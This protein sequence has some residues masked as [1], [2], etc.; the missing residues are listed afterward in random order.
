MSPRVHLINPSELSFGVAVITPPGSRR[1]APPRVPIHRA[2]GRQFL[3][4]HDVRSRGCASARRPFAPG[5]ARGNPRRSGSGLMEQLAQLPGDLVF[6]TQITME[7][8]EDPAFLAAMRRAHILGALV[9]VE[10]V[11]AEELKDVYK[12][13]NLSGDALVARLRTFTQHGVHVLGSFIFGL[14]SD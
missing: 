14:P 7:A 13:F 2:G 12:D 10:S 3:S 11:T 9:G 1:I 5:S 6:Y 8:A 4:G